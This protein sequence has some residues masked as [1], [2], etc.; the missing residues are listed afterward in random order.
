MLRKYFILE[1]ILILLEFLIKKKK[2]IKQ[3]FIN[4]IHLFEQ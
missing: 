2:E 1:N 4:I 3:I